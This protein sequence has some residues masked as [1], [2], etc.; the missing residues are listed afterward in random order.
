MRDGL[1]T[2]DSA[3]GSWTSEVEAAIRALKDVDG[4]NIQ[5][6][7][8]DIREIHVLTSSNRPAKHIVRDVQTLLLTKDAAQALQGVLA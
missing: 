5:S 4:V 8:D 3:Q 2:V 1:L 7:G 6:E